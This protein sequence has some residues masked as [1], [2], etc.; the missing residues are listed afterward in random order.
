MDLCT[1]PCFWDDLF[2][3]PYQKFCR[4][5]HD[6]QRNKTALQDNVDTVQ[7]LIYPSGY[8]VHTTERFRK[9]QH[10][11]PHCDK[12][13]YNP[14]DVEWHI[15]V[16]TGEGLS[17]VNSVKELFHAKATWLGI[18]PLFM[19]GWLI[20]N[21]SIQRD[22]L[23]RCRWAQM[24]WGMANSYCPRYDPSLARPGPPCINHDLLYIPCSFI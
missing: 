5:S 3:Q 20:I 4:F 8:S 17:N 19:G 23:C 15:R 1:F 22:Y 13:F 16:H 6:Y 12:S 11:C 7:E 2:Y 21:N 18:W 9:R 24:I 14:S 10:A